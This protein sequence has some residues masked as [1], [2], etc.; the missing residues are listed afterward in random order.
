[1]ALF[2]KETYTY[3]SVHWDIV[4]IKGSLMEKDGIKLINWFQVPE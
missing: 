2:R 4:E 1:M 3:T